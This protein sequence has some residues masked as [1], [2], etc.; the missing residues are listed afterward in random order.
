MPLKWHYNSCMGK[1]LLYRL[2]SVL[3]LALVSLMLSGLALGVY[4]AGQVAVTRPP[5]RVLRLT[6]AAAASPLPVT[7]IARFFQL[8]PAAAVFLDE[9]L[10]RYGAV[11][12][13]AGSSQV[14]PVGAY[15]PPSGN[16]QFALSAPTPLPTPFPYPTSPPLPTAQPSPTPT[17]LAQMTPTSAAGSLPIPSGTSG[18]SVSAAAVVPEVPV[19]QPTTFS[20]AVRIDCAPA[21]F[22]VEG[23]LTQRF[24][25][26]HPGIDLSQPLGA[27]VRATHSGQVAFTGWSD[28][29]YGYLVIVQSGPFITYYAHN[30]SVNVAVGDTVSKGAIV[31]WSGSTGNSSGPHVHYETRINDIPVDPLTFEA[32]GYPTC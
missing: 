8:D 22:P 32:R 24:T 2:Q 17:V 16:A 6:A 14:P 4:L 19:V 9:R 25:L 30:T 15:L 23:L 11:P 3:N 26:T 1:W 31:A 10:P 21:G 27:P 28:I 29:G 13:E 20:A 18:P 5:L 12:V 7:S